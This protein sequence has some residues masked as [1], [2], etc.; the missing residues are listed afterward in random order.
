M[1]YSLPYPLARTHEHMVIVAASPFVQST[2]SG[3]G[4]LVVGRTA[5]GRDDLG[6]TIAPNDLYGYKIADVDAPGK[7]AKILL[8]GGNHPCETPGSHALEG[9][10][11]FLLS[12]APE[13]VGLRRLAEFYV[14]P[15][16]NP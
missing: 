1:A 15:Q 9:M 7:K 10:I 14:Y 5:G 4:G 16:I 2:T 3:N 13:A 12:D 11:D 6:R 8:S